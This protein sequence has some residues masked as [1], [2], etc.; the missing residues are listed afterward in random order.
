MTYSIWIYGPNIGWWLHESGYDLLCDAAGGLQE[1]L[2]N[3]EWTGGAIVPD[4]EFP[5]PMCDAC[6]QAGRIH[7]P[8][9]S[10]VN[11]GEGERGV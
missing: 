11:C 9:V 2:G 6:L 5:M 10:K 1:A 3:P 8:A 4:G 7:R